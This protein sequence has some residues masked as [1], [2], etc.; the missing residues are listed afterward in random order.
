[1]KKLLFFLLAFPLLL[2]SQ[3]NE[4]DTLR[5]K[6]Q[7][8]LSGVWQEGN[9]E[10]QIFRAK[11]GLTYRPFNGWVVKSQNSYVYQ[12][13]GGTKADEDIL[14]LNFLYLNPERRLY[15]QVLGFVSNN[16]RRAIDL[17]YLLGMGITYQ[18]MEKK[19]QW[20]KFSISSEF[21]K[22]KFNQS[23]FNQSQYNGSSSISTWRGTLWINGRYALLDKKLVLTHESFLQPSLQSSDNYRW[24]ADLGL[25]IPLVKYLNFKINY[26]HA[27]ESI[28]IEGQQREDQFLTFGFSI[29]SY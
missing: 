26:L 18:L 24:Q 5:V 6:A 15:P 21:E 13:F 25:E 16:F 8:A 10:T 1:M 3:I 27:F 28:V 19:N 14:S 17:R 23:D 12:A 20:L 11:Q 29:K 2:Y 9:V 4:S 22:T 7:L